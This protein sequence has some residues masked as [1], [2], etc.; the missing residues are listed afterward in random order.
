MDPSRGVCVIG[1]TDFHTGIGTVTASA[2]EIFSRFLPVSLFPCRGGA[3]S[4]GSHVTLPR[5]R[6][7]PVTDQIDG[8]SVY[9]FTDV[10]WN[11]VS[12]Y[13][14]QSV[15][16]TGYRIA[17]IA[18][19]SDHLP[20]E[21]VSILNSRFDL[22][23]FSS[24]HL[25][26]VARDSGVVIE[27]G[28]LPIGLEIED[29]LAQK[30]AAPP[31]PQTT[32][33]GS[34]SAF[35]DRKG[36]DVLVDAFLRE[37]DDTEDVELVLHSNLAMGDTYAR[38]SA[39][40]SGSTRARVRI[41]HGNLSTTAKNALIE[42][43]DVYVNASAGE[44]YSIGPREAMALGKPLVLTD[45]GAHADMAGVEGVYLVPPSGRAPARYPEID[46]RVFGRQAVFESAKLGAVLR[47][48][49]QFVHTPAA[50]ASS[51]V[52]KR[53]AAEFSMTAMEAKYREVVD[54]GAPLAAGRSVTSEFTRIPHAS[55]ER[56]L[57]AAG[58][59]GGKIGRRKVVLPLHDAGFFSLF[60]VLATH[61]TWSMQ[62]S[63]PPM[64]LPDWDVTRLIERSNGEP[65]VSYCYSKP[66]DGNMWLSLFEP[67]YD[68]SADDMNNVEFL[69]GNANRPDAHFNERREPLLTY[70]NAFELYRAPW[71]SRFRTQYSS[72]IRD[73]VRLIPE[74][75]LQVDDIRELI[76]SRFT[77]AAHVKH[78]SHSIEQPGG[79]MAERHQYIAE[80][81]DALRRRGISESS[82]D[83][84]VFIAT[85][86]QRVVQLFA[87][88]FGDHVLQMDDVTRIGLE[89][90]A[91][92]DNLPAEERSLEGHQ[93][94]HLMAADASSW[95][96]RLAWEVWRDAEAMAASD[97]LIHAVSN[98]ATA[99]SYLGDVEMVYCDPEL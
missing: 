21:W 96:T 1:R 92:Y 51:I 58:T 4:H 24:L 47:E 67:L 48:A 75:Q 59:H 25:E 11:G 65:F 72:V 20:P 10:L 50:A 85:D 29:L 54:P 13:H 84:A 76:S 79:V 64:I 71:F 66:N 16:E 38:V 45:I 83:W 94:Q 7:V 2:L 17:H 41:S 36:L 55:R 8:F 19:D 63:S 34:L 28:S 46:N 27:V 9:F 15:P 32:R 68:L 56:A 78:P 86:Q 49:H 81:R 3:A 62:E 30:Y 33:F 35:H 87:E 90:D 80:V 73:R 95:S 22:A 6:P 97:V 77:I 74:Y 52:R 18:Y 91:R 70:T 93:L 37:F 44:G 89:T 99:V 69:Y 82:N 23:L 57:A 98:V 60:N 12:D 39:L 42:S 61:L 14:Y 31:L 26:Q 40:V 5:G 43:F 88:E 53:R